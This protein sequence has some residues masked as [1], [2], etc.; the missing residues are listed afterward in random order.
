MPSGSL[1]AQLEIGGTYSWLVLLIVLILLVVAV[2]ALLGCLCTVY[3]VIRNRNKLS[4]EGTPRIERAVGKHGTVYVTIPAEE[5]GAGKIQLNLQNQTVE[6]LALTSG[7]QLVPGAKVVV[8][9]VVDSNTVQV[10]AV[11]E[12]DE[13][14]DHA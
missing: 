8:T 11:L 4:A 1:F 5:T 3:W 10:E 7:R 13:R 2:T 6:Y 14:N 9:D 12:T